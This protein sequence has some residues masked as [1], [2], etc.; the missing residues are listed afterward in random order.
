MTRVRPGHAVGFRL[1]APRPGLFRPRATPPMLAFLYALGGGHPRWRNCSRRSSGPA[2]SSSCMTSVAAGRA[3]AWGLLAAL[4]LLVS[5]A[6][7]LQ[8]QDPARGLA[9]P[10]KRA[11]RDLAR[12]PRRAVPAA[13]RTAHCSFV[14]AHTDSRYIFHLP[15]FVM[16]YY[17][18]ALGR[19]PAPRPVPLVR[20]ARRVQAS[21]AVP[22]VTLL[23]SA[24]G[25][26]AT[27]WRTI[28]SCWSIRASS[29]GGAIAR[30]RRW[31]RSNSVGSR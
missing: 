24:R 1:D 23:L 3:S 19:G 18:L 2:R 4:W 8:R 5:P 16:G 30:R 20:P 29:G 11:A 17:A 14:L 25:A 7:R 6:P 9:R 27:R 12:G 31:R 15:F 13:S 21:G 22:E 10:A 26:S 28:T